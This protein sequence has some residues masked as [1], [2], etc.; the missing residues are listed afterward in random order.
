MR[1]RFGFGQGD[2]MLAVSRLIFDMSVADVFL[3]LIAGGTIVLAPGDSVA[4]PV[5]LAALIEESRCSLLQAT[6]AIWQSLISSG[7]AGKP[8]MKAISGGEALARALADR[9]LERGVR[10]WNGYGPTEATIYTTM[11]EV[12][13]DG[14]ISIGRPIDN[15]DVLIVDDREHDVPC[16]VP[17][18]CILPGR[19]SRGAIA[20][21]RRPR[22]RSSS[23]TE[24]G[25]IAAGTSRS[26][27]A[28][29]ASNGKD[30]ATARSRFGDSASMSAM[31][32]RRSAPAPASPWRP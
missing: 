3:P 18:H 32:R 28:T 13:R 16:N 14:A 2:T 30:E 22:E 29:A 1:R 20:I 25:C 11:E 31:S 5:L 21:R 10:L 8:E 26:V 23:A 17:G 27:A 7:W 9:L 6:P 15:I 12:R 24:G 4:D 19:G